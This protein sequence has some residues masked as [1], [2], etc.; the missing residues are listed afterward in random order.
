MLQPD[1]S[2]VLRDCL[3]QEPVSRKHWAHRMGMPG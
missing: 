3:V 1:A 2:I